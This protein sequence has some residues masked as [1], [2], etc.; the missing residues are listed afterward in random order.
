MILT[1]ADFLKNLKYDE[2]GLIA[3]VVQYITN[4]QVLMVGYMNKEAVAKTLK[5]PFVTFYSRSR[6]KMWVKGE[7]SGHTQEV[8]EI[9]YDCDADCLLI[10]AKQNVAACHVGYRSCFY[11]KYDFVSQLVSI[12][13]EKL[14]EEEKVYSKK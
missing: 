4:N 8:C 11:R 6:Q 7:S 5:G 2:H 12:V 3:A 1:Q 14:F 10:K 9:Y 13:G